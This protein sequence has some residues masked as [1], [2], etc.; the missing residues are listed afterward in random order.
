MMSNMQVSLAWSPLHIHR[1]Y[2]LLLIIHFLFPRCDFPY[3]SLFTLTS[4]VNYTWCPK[5]IYPLLSQ[6]PLYTHYLTDPSTPTTSTITYNKG[7]PL[8]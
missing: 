1:L 5:D 8:P 4:L 2:V 7:T 6:A 3:C